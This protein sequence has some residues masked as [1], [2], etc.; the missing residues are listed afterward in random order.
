MGA[1]IFAHLTSK[2]PTGLLPAKAK[3][4]GYTL[5]SN[6][7]EMQALKPGQ[8]DLLACLFTHSVMGY[9][10]DY[11]QGKE[12]DYDTMP[13]LSEIAAK[14]VELLAAEPKG[15]FLMV[16]GGTIDS[17]SHPHETERALAETVEFSKAVAAV[18]AWAKDRD[19][20][21]VIVTADHET[22]G[23]KVVKNNGKGEFPTVEWTAPDHTNAKVGL[24]AW[25][26]GAEAAA[27]ARDNTDI[28][29]LMTGTLT[30]ETAGKPAPNPASRPATSSAPALVPAGAGM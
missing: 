18:M 3:Q 5:V 1:Y 15:F 22:G 13:H 25:G 8:A 17:A 24:W 23:M 4:A 11:A 26:V 12:K 20:T 19:D 16:E 2:K 27:L 28:F 30:A 6:R 14:A 7:S 10:Y 21:L 29:K 9:E